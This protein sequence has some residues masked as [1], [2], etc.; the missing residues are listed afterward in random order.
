MASSVIAQQFRCHVRTIERLLNHFRQTG[1]TSD[2]PGTGCPRVTTQHQDRHIRTTHLRNRF[3]PATVTARTTPGTHNQRISDQTVRNRLREVG[4][5]PR[6][7]YVGPNLTL[8]HRRNRAQ[9]VTVHQR[10]RLLQWR[11]ILF[12]DESRFCLERRDGRVL[13]YRRRNERYADA[14]VMERDRF[15]GGSVIIWGGITYQNRT[16]LIPVAGTLTAVKYRDDILAAE[17]LLFINANTHVTFQQDNA[18]RHTARVTRDFLNTNNVN[19]LPW[20]SKSPDL[21]PIKHLWDALDRKIRN[22]PVVPQTLPALQQ[23]LIREW[24][25]IPRQDIQ[26]LISSMRRSCIAVV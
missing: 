5:R 21:N 6:R 19:V 2:G 13:V 26:R 14:C 11:N 20:R 12:S 10:W 3:I 8:R 1:T 23:L 4:L 17:V 7:P 18:P 22:L 24:N 16:R 9:W 15:G 25:N